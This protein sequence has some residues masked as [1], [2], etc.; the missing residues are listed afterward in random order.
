M[1]RIEKLYLQTLKY[2]LI[3]LYRCNGYQH[4]KI[5]SF[6][7]YQ[8][9]RVTKLNMLKRVLGED[10]PDQAESMIGLKRMDNI[11]HCIDTVISEEIPGDL[12]EAGVW[13]GGASIFMAANLLVRNSDK[14]LFVCD[15]F[16]GLPRPSSIYDIGDVHYK[17]N[18]LSVSKD[19]VIENFVK[20]GLL[21]YKINFIEGWFKDTMPKMRD[22]TFSLLRLDGDMYE[23]TRDVLENIY[24]RLAPGGFI[25]I[26]DFGLAPCRSAVKMFRMARN[27]DEPMITIDNTG[28]YWRKER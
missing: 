11:Q 9:T 26:D 5:F 21:S 16:S 6:G 3:D 22:H 27:I 18:I 28:V 2:N 10:W 13:R 12:L 23:S 7:P 14:R 8:F 20:Y 25:I 15:S 17:H 24:D 19:E 4:K 1:N